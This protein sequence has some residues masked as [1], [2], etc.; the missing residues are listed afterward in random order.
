ML[1][2]YIQKALKKAQYKVL[3]NGT[4]FAEISAFEGVWANAK[5]V[6]E[7]RQELQ[8]V[9][10]EWL[11]LKIRDGDLIPEIEGVEIKIKEVA[12]A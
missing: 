8:E 2:E 10:E 6:E 11:L 3:D 7:C 1:Y 5:S 9:L 12:A 4:W